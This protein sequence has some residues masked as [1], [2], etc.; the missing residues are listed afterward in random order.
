MVNGGT[1]HEESVKVTP[2]RKKER[3]AKK[4]AVKK[5]GKASKRG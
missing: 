4:S 1:L 3:P 5:G 2:P